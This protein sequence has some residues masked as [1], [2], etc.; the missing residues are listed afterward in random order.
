MPDTFH[1]NIEDARIGE[2]L[3]RHGSRVRYVHLADSNRRAP[4][5]GHVDFAEVFDGLRRGGFDGWAAVEVLP[6]PDADTAARQAAEFLLPMVEEF[7]R[8]RG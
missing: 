2:A 1:M 7:N 4:G 8:G 3:A 5:Q 6:V